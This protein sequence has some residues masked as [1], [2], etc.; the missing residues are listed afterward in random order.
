MESVVHNSK[1]TEVNKVKFPACLLQGRALTWWN[2]QVQTRGRETANRLTWEEFKRMLKEEYCPR[3]EIQKLEAEL[4]NHEM[5][6][7]GIDSYTTRF[8]E[9]AKLVPH[10]VTPEENSL[11]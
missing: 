5:V 4:W 2:T 6:G 1:C 10:L 8:H 9:L 3:S 11:N 7:S